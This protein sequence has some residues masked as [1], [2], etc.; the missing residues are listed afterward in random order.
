MVVVQEDIVGNQLFY[1]FLSTKRNPTLLSRNLVK[2]FALQRQRFEGQVTPAPESEPAFDRGSWTPP[3]LASLETMVENEKIQKTLVLE[4]K[5]IEGISTYQPSW[6]QR[7]DKKVLLFLLD[8]DIHFDFLDAKSLLQCQGSLKCPAK[9]QGIR[10]ENGTQASLVISRQTI[11]LDDLVKLRAADGQSSN[12]KHHPNGWTLVLSINFQ[13]P[14][15]AETFYASLTPTGSLLRVDNPTRLSL[16]WSDIRECPGEANEVLPLSATEVDEQPTLGLRLKMY[17]TTPAD[18][19]LLATHNRQL[20]G[21]S[22]TLRSSVSRSRESS[23]HVTNDWTVFEALDQESSAVI[24]FECPSCER[25]L[26]RS[27][28]DLHSHLRSQ[29]RLLDYTLSLEKKTGGMEIW[30][31]TCT[32]ASHS[33]DHRASNSAPDPREIAHIMPEEPFN[34]DKYLNE[35]DESWHA[36]ARSK[37]EQPYRRS[38]FTTRTKKPSE[39]QLISKWKKKKY[40]VPTPPPNVTFFRAATKRPLKPDE[41][42]SESEDDADTEWLKQRKA[43]QLDAEWDIP[44]TTKRFVKIFDDFIFEEHLHSQIHTSDS[45]VRF[46]KLHAKTLRREN[47]LDEFESKLNQLLKDDLITRKTR[48]TC[49]EIARNEGEQSADLEQTRQ[50]LSLALVDSLERVSST[51]PIQDIPT[52]D[53]Q[54]KSRKSKGK[55]RAMVTATGQWT[56]VTESDADVEMRDVESLTLA[57]TETTSTTPIPNQCLCGEDAI[58]GDKSFVVCINKVSGTRLTFWSSF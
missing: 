50:R 17:W 41:Y 12:K 47:L 1:Q 11:L 18:D 27:T 2:A 16:K 9:L 4:L 13:N 57:L 3:T 51:P 31:L 42:I 46:A 55:G 52:R 34:E 53:R 14:L 36:L 44:A 32:I 22:S 28:R 56:P 54:T 5:G 15:D 24:G 33:A 7:S 58:A 48:D 38:V 43:A 49:M 21:S 23:T 40:R 20:K 35:G 19:S 37:A 8:V 29:H 45:V 6:K 39:V 25:K 30:R 10:N 26:F